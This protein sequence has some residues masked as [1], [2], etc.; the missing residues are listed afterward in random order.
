MRYDKLLKQVLFYKPTGKTPPGK[1]PKIVE[2][3][4][5]FAQI[6]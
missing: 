4:K 1:L 3:N 6:I 5:L 2:T